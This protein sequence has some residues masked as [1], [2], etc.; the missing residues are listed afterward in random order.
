[1]KELK[2]RDLGFDCEAVVSATN[3]NE[4]LAQVAAHA[5]EAHG[6]TDEQLANPELHAQVRSHTHE[7]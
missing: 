4:V 2:C 7:R 1:M 5:K 3:D 6:F